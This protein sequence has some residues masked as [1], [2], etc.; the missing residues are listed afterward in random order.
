MKKPRKIL[1]PP[2]PI[3]VYEEQANGM[4]ARTCL[5]DLCPNRRITSKP[6]RFSNTGLITLR[7]ASANLAVE[8]NGKA[9][10]TKSPVQNKLGQS[11]TVSFR[12]DRV[13]KISNRRARTRIP[14]LKHAARLHRCRNYLAIA[15]H[16]QS[17]KQERQ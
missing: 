9:A 3:A 4:V 6:R 7:L 14:L 5:G 12:L 15:H 2:L 1:T 17:C 10:F 11:P 8:H 13:E 16:R